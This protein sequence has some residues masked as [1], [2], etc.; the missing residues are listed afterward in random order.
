MVEHYS[1]KIRLSPAVQETTFHVI[2]LKRKGKGVDTSTSH[3][4]TSHDITAH[5]I[6]AQHITEQHKKAALATV[7]LLLDLV[8]TLELAGATI[9][10]IL[11]QG[12]PQWQTTAPKSHKAEL[13]DQGDLRG[14]SPGAA[15][16]RGRSLKWWRY[17]TQDFDSNCDTIS[18][19]LSD[20]HDCRWRDCNLPPPASSYETQMTMAI[21]VR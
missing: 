12:Y 7:L 2:V 3:D 17:C 1:A 6:T 21:Y 20:P 19:M 11:T 14:R 8:Q 15:A 5:H 13:L 18:Y 16:R 4:I 9:Y 10:N